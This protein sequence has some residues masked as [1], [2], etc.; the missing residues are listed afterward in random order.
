LDVKE[1]T[2]VEDIEDVYENTSQKVEVSTL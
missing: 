1:V 2:E